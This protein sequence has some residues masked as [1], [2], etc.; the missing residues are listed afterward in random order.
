MRSC[1]GLVIVNLDECEGSV[2]GNLAATFASPVRTLE[3]EKFWPTVFNTPHSP[4]D[5]VG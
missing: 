2:D 3:A 4:H 1:V 5:P